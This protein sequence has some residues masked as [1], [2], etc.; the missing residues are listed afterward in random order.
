MT[1]YHKMSL[2]ILFL[3]LVPGVNLFAQQDFVPELIMSPVK[4]GDYVTGTGYS[5]FVFDYDIA[6]TEV[7]QKL[8]REVMGYNNSNPVG[9]NL[10]VNN[11]NWLEAVEFCNKLSA[12]MGYPKVYTIQENGDVFA[13]MTVAGMRLPTEEEWEYAA[14]VEGSRWV[15]SMPVATI[16]TRLRGMLVT[17]QK[18]SIQSAQ[19]CLMNLGYLI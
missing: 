4:G 14:K 18:K 15:I 2:I 8:W 11:V 3:A 10:P 7:D 1:T 6:T 13:D 9:D 16:L 17:H 19:R 5:V 12:I